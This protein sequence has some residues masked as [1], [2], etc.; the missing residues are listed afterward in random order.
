[1]AHFY[2]QMKGN[3]G[4]ATRCGT[5]G[6]GMSVQAAGWKGAIDVQLTARN[7]HDCYVVRLTPWMSSG[8]F[9]RIIAEGKLDSVQGIDLAMVNM[10]KAL[11]DIQEQ[12]E[13]TR[14]PSP[15]Q[16]EQI[17]QVSNMVHLMQNVLE[18]VDV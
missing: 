5:K 15:K 16:R 3:K 14:N 10:R 4:E 7:D 2:A 9:A 17:M 13:N 11:R 8:G 6:S 1:M 12:A 18:G